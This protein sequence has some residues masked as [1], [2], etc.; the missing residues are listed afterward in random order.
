VHC[1]PLVGGGPQVVEGLVVF[2]HLVDVF[3]RGFFVASKGFTVVEDFGRLVG[4]L[5]GL[6][7]L[8]SFLGNFLELIHVSVLGE[9]DD[10]LVNLDD[11][12]VELGLLL[13]HLVDHLVLFFLELVTLHLHHFVSLTGGAVQ[14]PLT[15]VFFVVCESEAK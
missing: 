5:E 3:V 2:D 4:L 10:S 8:L 13:L 15:L 14:F 9:A 6:P 7:N 1:L 11:F 12:V